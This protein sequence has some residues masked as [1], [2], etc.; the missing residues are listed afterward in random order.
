MSK[1]KEIGL[2]NQRNRKR[3]GK[4]S[5][6]FMAAL[7]MSPC[8]IRAVEES[9]KGYDNP[10]R[11]RYLLLDSRIIEKSPRRDL[12]LLLLFLTAV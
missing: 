1:K 12:V 7:G 6:V 5:I 2:M 11:N 9:Q 8:G 3:I 10:N 4:V